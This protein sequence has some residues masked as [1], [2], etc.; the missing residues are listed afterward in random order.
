MVIETR[1]WQND[2]LD[3]I[4]R[5]QPVNNPPRLSIKSV[6]NLEKDVTIALFMVRRLAE[7]GKLSKRF[8]D[9]RAEVARCA[10]TGQPYRLRWKDVGELYELENESNVSKSAIFICNQFIHADFSLYYSRA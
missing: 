8:K 10:F 1:F 2:I 3:Y 6:V 7:A 4:K 5:F 9:H